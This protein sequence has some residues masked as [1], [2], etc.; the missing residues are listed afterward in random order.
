MFDNILLL[1][2]FGNDLKKPYVNSF[3][4][5]LFELRAKSTDGIA[6]AFFTFKKD[7]IIIIFHVFIKKTQKTPLQELQKAR[8]IL[9]NLKD[10][11]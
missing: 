6:R 1:G 3:G 8:K 2:E 10:I 7:K 5:G 11:E 4:D 9:K